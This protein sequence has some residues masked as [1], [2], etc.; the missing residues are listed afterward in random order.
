MSLNS[1]DVYMQNVRFLANFITEAGII[2]KRSKVN[3]SALL[4]SRLGKDEGV[5][6]EKQ[7]MRM[8]NN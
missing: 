8:F 1:F 6:K 2:I 4:G 3:C 7:R 5:E